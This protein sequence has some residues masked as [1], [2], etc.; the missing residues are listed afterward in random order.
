VSGYL[1]KVASN[2]LLKELKTF[3]GNCEVLYN[4]MDVWT[5]DYMPI[6]LTDDVFLSYTYKPDYLEDEP[7]T[8]TNWQVHDV[9]TQKQLNKDV[10]WDFKVVQMPLILD[11]G[12]VVKAV[13]DGKPCIIMCEKRLMENNVNFEDFD[14]WW[15]RW[16]SENF[17]G[18]E[19]EYVMLPWD[20]YEDNP[21]GHADDMV[22]YI[23]EGRVLMTNYLDYDKAYKDYH[24]GLMKE[25]LEEVGFEVEVLSYLDKFDYEHDELFRMMLDR[26]WSYINYCRWVIGYWYLHWAIQIS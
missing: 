12:N 24:G 2:E 26:T 15:H 21:I 22:R 4:T 18:T 1:D 13:V 6:Q 19:M 8:I 5:R 17:D 7:E 23:D 25:R 10:R 11:D 16:W 3:T 9:H 20:G 14:N